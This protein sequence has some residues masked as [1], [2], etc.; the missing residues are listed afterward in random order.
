MTNNADE[1]Q[2]YYALWMGIISMEVIPAFAFFIKECKTTTE[3]VSSQLQR[4][5]TTFDMQDKEYDQP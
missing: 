3:S 2:I 1:F 4:N 5:T